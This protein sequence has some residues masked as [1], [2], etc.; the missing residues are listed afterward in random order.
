MKQRT[1]DKPAMVCLQR[2]LSGGVQKNEDMV[3][4]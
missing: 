4:E 1:E 2:K 3:S